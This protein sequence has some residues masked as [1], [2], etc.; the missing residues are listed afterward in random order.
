MTLEEFAKLP[1]GARVRLTRE[2]D[3]YPI[4]IFPA[5]LLGTV[6]DVSRDRQVVAMVRLDR[7][8]DGLDEWQNALQVYADPD[9]STCTPD[10]WEAFAPGLVREPVRFSFDTEAEFDGFTDGTT[11]NGFLNVWVTPE[12]RDEIAATDDIFSTSNPDA[13]AERDEFKGLE[14]DESGLICLAYG[15]ATQPV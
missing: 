15:Y 2:V 1:V 6:A 11:W 14:P 13:Q 9:E 8:Y 10:A 7:H 3:I 4:D 5:G 12:T